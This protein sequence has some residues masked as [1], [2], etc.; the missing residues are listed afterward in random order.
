MNDLSGEEQHSLIV[1]G[2]LESL[3]VRSVS[4]GIEN[5]VVMSQ[6]E[7]I[8]D[9]RSHKISHRQTVP[10]NLIGSLLQKD[11]TSTSSP[12]N[13]GRLI[14][15]RVDPGHETSNEWDVG[16]HFFPDLRHVEPGRDVFEIL[17][18]GADGSK[19]RS[20]SF[21]VGAILHLI[22][23][24][25]HLSHH[26]IFVTPAIEWANNSS[27]LSI[28]SLSFDHIKEKLK[29]SSIHVPLRIGVVSEVVNI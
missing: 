13:N 16:T 24:S 17:T 7:K 9:C 19:L 15:P 12:F 22:D 11:E 5:K 1:H 6:I 27:Q 21:S 8:L 29:T 26:R 25:Q 18:V 2:E 14:P 3:N 10:A 4:S 23:K 28:S 20:N